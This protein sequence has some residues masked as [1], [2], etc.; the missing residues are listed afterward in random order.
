MATA[1]LATPDGLVRDVI[2][3]VASE[4]TLEAFVDSYNDGGQ[5]YRQL[6]HSRIRSSYGHHYR[7]MLPAVLE[8]IDFRCNNKQYQPILQAVDLLK[9]YVDTP[10]NLMPQQTTFP[11]KGSSVQT[12]KRRY[13]IRMKTSQ[14]K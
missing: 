9:A 11:S 4:Q 7:Q 1:A 10:E 2:Y 8:V 5:T 14:T 3:P 12:G 13:W 6:L